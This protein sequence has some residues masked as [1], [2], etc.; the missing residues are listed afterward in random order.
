[1]RY[2]TATAFR[3]AL[4][5]RLLT[6]SRE[7]SMTLSRLRKLVA[8]DRLLARITELEPDGW[9]LKGALSL[10]Y[11]IGASYRGT[12]DLDLWSA[13]SAEHASRVLLAVPTVDFGD[14]FVFEVEHVRDLGGD[15]FTTASFAVRLLLADRLFEQFNTDLTITGSFD[16]PLE[17]V[18]GP[19]LLHFAGIE[20]VRISAT[21]IELQIAEKLH[22]YVQI[23][24]GGRQSSR[25]KDLVDLFVIRTVQAYQAGTVRSALAVVFNKRVTTALPKFLPAPPE[26]WRGRYPKLAA[27][28]G[29]TS[30]V[31]L[32]HQTVALFLD[33]IL[34]GSIADNAV[35][36]PDRLGWS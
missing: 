20:P 25:V 17:T 7:T 30:D 9:V 35:W 18:A 34:D 21:P 19:P 31:A 12:R 4:E 36:N 10:D 14:Y 27:E 16:E 24:P 6:T 11:R 23:Y 1:M 8:F 2:S 29:I 5:T 28:A 15:E 13:H 22:A 32:A 26:A 3:K 33:P